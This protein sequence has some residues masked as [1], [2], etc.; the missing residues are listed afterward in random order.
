MTVARAA[1][2]EALGFVW[3]LSAEAKSPQ[4]SQGLLDDTGWGV[5]LSK[6]KQ[7][8]REHGDCNVPRG[9]AEDPR[10][11]HWVK[12]QRTAKKEL[13]RGDPSNG[14]T[15][16]RAAKLEAL[17][18]AWAPGVKSHGG[19]PNEARWEAQLVRQPSH[20]SSPRAALEGRPVGGNA[21]WTP[22]ELATLAELTK[23][24]PIT[25]ETQDAIAAQLGT[26]RTGIAVYRH[27]LRIT[28]KADRSGNSRAENP[29]HPR[30]PKAGA[31]GGWASGGATDA[32]TKVCLLSN[33]AC[34]ISAAG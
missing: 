17:G 26:N 31:S 13:D 6:L 29:A 10:L 19:R 7:Y 5:W 18:L 33:P 24:A 1:K 4:Q 20:G 23:D 28:P 3:E 15:A 8:T 30:K 27:W 34:N 11:G 12:E 25:L 22:A 2:L 14:M 21:N 9:W 16:E 32:K